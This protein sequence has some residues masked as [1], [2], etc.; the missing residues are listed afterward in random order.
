MPKYK[1]NVADVSFPS[2]KTSITELIINK[3]SIDDKAPATIPLKQHFFDDIIPQR[4]EPDKTLAIK[5]APTLPLSVAEF[6]KAY[7]KT[8]LKTIEATEPT[9]PAKSNP[10]TFL[11]V[12]DIFAVCLLIFFRIK[13][14]SHSIKNMREIFLI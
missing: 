3:C 7:E 12:T 1:N 10:I 14:P 2:E 5:K 6:T 13:N 11:D 4:N 9:M 8:K